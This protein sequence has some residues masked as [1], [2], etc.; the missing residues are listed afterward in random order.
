MKRFARLPSP[1]MLVALSAL[2]VALGGVSYGFATGSIDSREIRNNT[3]RTRDIRNNEVRGRDIRNSTIRS[4]DIGTNQ[5][6]GVD[7]D[8]STLGQVPKAD[9][10]N[11]AGSA[12]SAGSLKSQDKLSYQA[13]T[14]AGAQQIYRRGALTLRASCM[15]GT[16]AVTANTS[17]SNATIQTNGGSGDD[18]DFDSD[19][20]ATISSGPGVVDVVYSTPRGQV[21]TAQFAVAD[22]V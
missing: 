2:F 22:G 20:T 12:D 10:A 3:I 18:T 6:K 17:E 14:G 7:I 19:E 15:G 13:A 5:V 21:V 8:E 1:A 9:K 11:T 16:T 4:R